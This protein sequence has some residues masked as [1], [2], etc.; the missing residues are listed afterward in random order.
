MFGQ[1]VNRT[2]AKSAPSFPKS[3]RDHIH[4]AVMD[5]ATPKPFP[6]AY[7]FHVYGNTA[8]EVATE[9][10]A[11]FVERADDLAYLIG[12][13]ELL[14]SHAIYGA[15]GADARA[16]LGRIARTLGR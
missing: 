7:G 5:L 6:A 15:N 11:S 4:L 9:L 16:L 1:N 14:W 13:F 8:A 10:G 2:S 3:E 12:R